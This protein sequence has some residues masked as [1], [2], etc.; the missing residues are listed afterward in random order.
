MKP[1]LSRTACLA[2][3]LPALA[4]AHEGHGLGGPHGHATDVLGF[5]VIVVLVGVA[6]WS[7]RK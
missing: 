3:L 2:A 7:L 5:I 6:I 1:L 4:R